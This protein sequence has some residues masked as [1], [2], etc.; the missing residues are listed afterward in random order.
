M[1]SHRSLDIAF[2]VDLS[3]VSTSDWAQVQ[4]Y[5]STVVQRIGVAVN[6]THIALATAVHPSIANRIVFAEVTDPNY[7]TEGRNLSAAVSYEQYLLDII[8]DLLRPD[9]S[10]GTT[11]IETHAGIDHMRNAVFSP[12]LGA[13][14]GDVQPVLIVLTDGAALSA[15][16][17]TAAANLLRTQRQV[18]VYAAGFGPNTSALADSL[19]GVVGG[20]RSA[21]STAATLSGLV[22]REQATAEMT[23]RICVTSAPSATPTS[24]PT[25]ICPRGTQLLGGVCDPGCLRACEASAG[26]IVQGCDGTAAQVRL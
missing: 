10:V 6:R 9:Q 22:A 3:N 16:A 11:G 26:R 4:A 19:L 5:L 18:A 12:E 13:R 21:V 24:A 7:R 15:S 20:D 8:N 25:V 23:Q 1:C 2:L 14:G 17:A